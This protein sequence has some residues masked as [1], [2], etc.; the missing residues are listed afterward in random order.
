MTDLNDV[1]RIAASLPETSEAAVDM[2]ERQALLANARRCQ[3]PPEL[4]K[5]TGPP[6]AE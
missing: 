3:A 6:G 2:D 1:R 5:R 4:L